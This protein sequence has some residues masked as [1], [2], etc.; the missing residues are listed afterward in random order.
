MPQEE[1]NASQDFEGGT[2]RF[3]VDQIRLYGTPTESLKQPAVA[4]KDR[5][6]Q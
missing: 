3:T 1:M 2:A 4:K 5:Q 6:R